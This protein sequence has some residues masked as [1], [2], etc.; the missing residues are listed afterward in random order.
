MY[1]KTYVHRDNHH[2]QVVVANA[3]QEAELP[4]GFILHATH[5]SAPSPADELAKLEQARAALAAD[6]AAFDDERAKFE[7]L[8][9]HSTSEINAIADE[10]ETE[11]Q[12]L[13]S[14]L[15]ELEGA[16]AVHEADRA[17]WEE[18]KA[19][20]QPPVTGEAGATPEAPPKRTRGAKAEG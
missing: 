5:G 1:P 11:R 15:A 20:A 12:K 9:A 3:E 16:R 10:L 4:A 8:R 17:A 14:G 6:R 19:S 2:A 18:Q 7:A 13:A